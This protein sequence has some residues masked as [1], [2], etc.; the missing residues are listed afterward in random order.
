MLGFRGVGHVNL[1]TRMT[2]EGMKSGG[3]ELLPTGNLA[4]YR[5]DGGLGTGERVFLFRESWGAAY[6]VVAA[7]AC[8][9]VQAAKSA[10]PE[11]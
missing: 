11:Q 5:G 1:A 2:I 8:Y 7:S 4:M 9:E 3:L 6:F 10:S